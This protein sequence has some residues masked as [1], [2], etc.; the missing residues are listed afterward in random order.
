MLPLLPHLVMLIKTYLQQFLLLSTCCPT[1]KNK[2]RGI[3]KDKKITFEDRLYIRIKHGTR[4]LE[5]SEQE[6]VGMVDM[7]WALMDKV[8]RVQEHMG[9][10]NRVV[11]IL[12]TKKKC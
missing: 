3:P 9:N 11:E 4:M 7:L 5:L 6:L 10:V 12:R 2:L 1:V 8:E